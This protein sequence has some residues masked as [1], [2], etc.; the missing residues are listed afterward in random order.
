MSSL[1]LSD[2][3]CQFFKTFLLEL[4]DLPPYFRDFE[5]YRFVFHAQ[6]QGQV[7]LLLQGLLALLEFLENILS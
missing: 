3:F 7:L 1:Q 2:T 6:S 4:I 5:G